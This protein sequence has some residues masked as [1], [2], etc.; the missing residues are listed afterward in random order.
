MKNNERCE[1]RLPESVRRIQQR[2][3]MSQKAQPSRTDEHLAML[4]QEVPLLLLLLTSHCSVSLLSHSSHAL[5]QLSSSLKASRKLPLSGSSADPAGTG[6]RRGGII[7]SKA[8]VVTAGDKS[9]SASW[10]PPYGV[11]ELLA[12]S[13][14]SEPAGAAVYTDVERDE[15]GGGDGGE[16]LDGRLPVEEDGIAGDWDVD[17]AKDEDGMVDKAIAVYE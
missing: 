9:T 14:D 6:S 13:A 4:V 10:R 15:R 16:A 8:T 17:G 3:T 12:E 7:F 1:L 11:T 2:I 5:R